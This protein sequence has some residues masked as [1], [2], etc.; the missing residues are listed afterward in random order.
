MSKVSVCIYFNLA[1]FPLKQE[2]EQ[3]LQDCSSL[4]KITL[5]F[6]EIRLLK[7]RTSCGYR[8]THTFMW[9][10]TCLNYPGCVVHI[11]TFQFFLILLT[12]TWVCE[13]TTISAFVD[14]KTQLR[15]RLALA[16]FK[17]FGSL[18]SI[19]FSFTE[20]GRARPTSCQYQTGFA[21][22]KTGNAQVWNWSAKLKHLGKV[23]CVWWS[24]VFEHLVCP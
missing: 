9:L 21:N 11:L 18:Y 1:S 16:D 15:S 3:K 23:I 14:G 10:S 22:C 4:S 8:N 7:P 13:K 12:C 20:A 5:L 2:C 17:I 6:R 19:S 24:S